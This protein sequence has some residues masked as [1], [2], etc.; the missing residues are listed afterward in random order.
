MPKYFPVIGLEI[1]CQLATRTKMF[2]GCEIEVNTSP[3]KHV[4]PVCLGMPGAM[5]VPNKK[6]VEYAIRL[7]LA[8][9][10]DIDLNAMWTR[11]NYFYPDLPKGYQIT[12]TGGLP[13]YDHP[14]CKNGWIEVTL[15]DGAVKRI[16][17]T[18]IH[19]E[20]DAGKLI[21]DAS[22]SESLFDANRCGTP[23][24][25]I[26]TEPDIRSPEEA[27]LALQKIKQILEYTE[28]SNANMENGNMRCDGNISLR[29]SEDAPYGTR[30][31]IKNLNSF[32]NLE[33]ALKAEMLYQSLVLDAGKEVEQ[34][35][36]RF[37]PNSNKTIVIRSKEDAHDYKYFPE[38]DMMRLVTD[39]EFAEEIRRTLP[40]LPDARRERFVESYGITPY[41]AQ[42]LTLDRE[43]SVWF[44]TAAKNCRN[45][46]MLANW[47]IS[48]LLREVKE[49]EGGLS[50]VKIRPEQ[51]ADLVNLIDDNTISGKIGKQVFAEMFATGKDPKKIVEEKG[52][53]QITDTS[54]IEAIVRDVIAANAAQFEEFKSGKSALKGFFVGQ[55][56]KKSGGKANPPLVNQLLDRFAGE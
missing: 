17:I 53:I 46:K 55:V 31:E 26:V 22:P 3:N 33:K 27:V 24:C 20:E 18:R 4:C 52:L 8:L 37:D 19:M 16:G 38:P 32:S 45:P 48:E 6:A 9:H 29:T 41:D 50:Q 25:E 2:C 40:E 44:D 10:C 36:K 43:V 49:L 7:G 23:L 56:M 15:A 34:C 5:P 42:V 47:V 11:K 30:S 1:H 35:T 14:I 21:H 12:Q 28:V 54:A 13:V 51:L 39:P